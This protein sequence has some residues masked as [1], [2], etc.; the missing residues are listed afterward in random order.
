MDDEDNYTSSRFH[1]PS[2]GGFS[3]L[4]ALNDFGVD[5][6]TV[7]R[8]RHEFHD[9]YH[10]FQVSRCFVRTHT[11]NFKAGFVTFFWRFS[12]ARIRDESS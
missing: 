5:P 4:L 7:R 11:M 3:R 9:Y 1:T 12:A 6:V 8:I 2:H 10:E